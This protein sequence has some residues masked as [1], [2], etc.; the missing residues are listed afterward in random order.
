M[1]GRGEG[2]PKRLTPVPVRLAVLPPSR[3]TSSSPPI[4]VGSNTARLTE[5]AHPSAVA[6][7]NGTTYAYD[8][9]QGRIYVKIVVTNVAQYVQGTVGIQLTP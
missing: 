5:V 6:Q 1:G 8:P 4:T 2:R 9:V 3:S 7:G